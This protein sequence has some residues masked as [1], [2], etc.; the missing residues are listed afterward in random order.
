MTD[1]LLYLAAGLCVATA[2]IHSYFGEKRLI[3]P[4]IRAG[5]GVMAHALARQVMRFAWHWTSALWVLVAGY[6]VYAAQGAV[7]HRPLI[8]GI[9]VAHLVAGVL[10]GLL[11]RGKHI[12][13]PPITLIG[14]LVLMASV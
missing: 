5:H 11:T 9:G 4:V 3:A 8:I 12:G 14:V 13:W 1:V 2:S 10:D 6:L 7:F